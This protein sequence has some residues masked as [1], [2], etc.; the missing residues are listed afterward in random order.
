M[1]PQT[2][3]DPRIGMVLQDRYRIV[4]KLGDGGMGAVYEGEHVLIKRK[5]AIKALHS[6]FA[7]NPEIVARFRREA[8]AATAIGHPNIIEVTDMGSFPDGTTYMVLEFLDGRDWSHDIEQQ[9]PQPLGKVVHV[10]TQVCDALAAAHAKGIVHRDLKPENIFLIERAGDPNFAKVLDFGIS[11]ITD[12]GGED[13]SLTQT[14]TALGTPYYMAPEQCQ[15][16]KDLDA[17]AD[18]YSLG[19][20]LFQA[21]TGQYPFD[22][23]SYPML[24]LKI[25]TEPPPPIEQYRPDLPPEVCATIYRMLAKDRS[26]RFST[27]TEVRDALAP[28][29]HV[30]DA[31]VVVEGPSTASRGPSVLEQRAST[32]F[33]STPTG[34]AYLPG[35]A[36]QRLPTAASPAPSRSPLVP[37]LAILGVVVVAAGG[38]GAAVTLGAFGGEPEPIVEVRTP[39]AGT[40]SDRA[41]PDAPAPTA[42]PDG[43]SAPANVEPAVQPPGPPQVPQVPAGAPTVRLQIA[44][45]GPTN[46]TVLVDGRTW[47]SAP[48]IMD[49][50]RDPPLAPG[51]APQLRQ[52]EARADGWQGPTLSIAFT[53]DVDRTI[54]M[55]RVRGGR[56]RAEPAGTST[57]SNPS[58]TTVQ[59]PARLDT[60]PA[61]PPPPPRPQ[62][63]DLADPFRDPP[64]RPTRPPAVGAGTVFGDP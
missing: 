24:V 11:K 64:P 46:A 45:E 33:P 5:V 47:G 49:V 43:P 60:R 7:Q 1:Q 10:V 22:D 29:R 56:R 19:V 3:Q 27:I 54:T 20:I 63:I 15:G 61:D 17:R 44:V 39:A 25:C 26:Q 62:P 55:E 4:R 16:K 58:T 32:P 6:Q 59:P 36:P 12:A 30:N 8:E 2:A 42:D 13:R 52:I 51:A 9:G 14:G 48:L 53:G 21:L 41:S 57:P 37:V 23:E 50:P 18:I 40:S 38:L 35:S 28:F 34:T 31:P